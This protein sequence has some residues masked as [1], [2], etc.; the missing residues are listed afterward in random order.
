MH[1]SLPADLRHWTVRQ[2]EAMGL[3]GPDDLILLLL[4]LE[5]QRQDLDGIE[6]RYR[7]VFRPMDSC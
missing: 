4:R 3:P 2:A 5:K 7:N 6:E 1:E